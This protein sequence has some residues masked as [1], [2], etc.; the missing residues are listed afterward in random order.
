MAG[1]A[2]PPPASDP[3]ALAEFKANDDPLEPTNRKLYAVNDALDRAVL[4]PVARTYRNVVPDPVRLHV[5]DFL[6]NLQG[7]VRFSNDVLQAKPRRAGDTFMRFLIN[8]TI[9]VA[10]IFD[11]ATDLGY[12]RHSTDFGIT[13]GTRG[14]G[15]GPYLYVPVAGPTNVRDAATVVADVALSPLNWV[16]LPPTWRALNLG[17]TVVSAVNTRASVLEQTE[18]VRRTSLD[19][20]ATYRSLYQQRRQA[21]IDETRADNRATVPAWFDR[22]AR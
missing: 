8:T 1:C 22:P 19:P 21:E 2:T 14:V 9:G 20:Y 10:G 11:V 13:L 5:G 3:E 18:V 17:R 4:R 6:D 7:P 15:P 16:G 12:P